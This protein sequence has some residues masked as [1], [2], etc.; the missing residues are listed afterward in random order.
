MIQTVK[1]AGRPSA[2]IPGFNPRRQGLY[3]IKELI[4]RGDRF[5]TEPVADSMNHDRDEVVRINPRHIPSGMRDRD[6]RCSSV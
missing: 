1:P 6:S 3:E 5:L 2:G 4:P